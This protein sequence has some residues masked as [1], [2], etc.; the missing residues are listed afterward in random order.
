[1]ARSWDELRADH[2][3]VFL[4]ESLVQKQKQQTP[5]ACRLCDE[6]FFDNKALLN[7]FQSHFHPDGTFN[8]NS[9]IRNFVLPE[10]EMKI[11]STSSQNG[12]SFLVPANAANQNLGTPPTPSFRNPVV[13][14]PPQIPVQPRGPTFAHRYH[15]YQLPSSSRSAVGIGSSGSGPS[16][17]LNF[18]STLRPKT[19]DICTSNIMEGSNTRF[20]MNPCTSAS[21]GHSRFVTDGSLP[22][23]IPS[24][25]LGKHPLPDLKN[26]PEDPFGHYTKPYIMQLDKPIEKMSDHVNV[27][28]DKSPDELDLTLKL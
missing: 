21:P 16:G 12:H 27:D 8:P 4:L 13:S 20:P 26:E 28:D 11:Y 9:L 25:S 23:W 24:T 15:P 19:P 10:T 18:F 7:H 1:M 17:P 5:I 3:L 22:S 6:I 14:V 2:K